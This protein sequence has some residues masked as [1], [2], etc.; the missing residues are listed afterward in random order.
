MLSINEYNT[1]GNSN[2]PYFCPFCSNDNFPFKSHSDEEFVAHTK[3]A[4]N[5]VLTNTTQY[6]TLKTFLKNYK[7]SKDFILLHVSARSL[8]KNF[9][10]LKEI[11]FSTKLCPDKD[12]ITFSYKLPN[13][14]F[15]QGNS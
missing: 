1:L 15:I 8:I 4:T 13:Y 14:I 6:C 11:I 3:T 10:K 9:S 2:L 7:N 5:Q 12:S